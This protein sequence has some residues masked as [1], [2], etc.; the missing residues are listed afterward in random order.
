MVLISTSPPGIFLFYC[1]IVLLGLTLDPAWPYNVLEWF[2]Y[3]YIFSSSLLGLDSSS[4]QGPPGWSP[5]GKVAHPKWYAD[6]I[7][8]K[9]LK[10]EGQTEVDSGLHN[11]RMWVFC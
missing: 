2:F 10:K 3:C 9:F 6:I 4:R 1:S 8:R 7:S 5:N 11:I